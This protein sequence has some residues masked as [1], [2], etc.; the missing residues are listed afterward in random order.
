M[1]NP[2]PDFE[3]LLTPVP[4]P[5]APSQLRQELLHQTTAVLRRRARIRRLTA[6][7]GLVTWFAAGLATMYF[8]GLWLQR[9]PPPPISP[10]ANVA[11]VP[12]VPGDERPPAR[13][14]NVSAARLERAGETAV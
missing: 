9:P 6:A 4:P 5:R 1:E 2:D 11:T 8:T 7:A 3:P 14:A 12:P 13:P 10:P